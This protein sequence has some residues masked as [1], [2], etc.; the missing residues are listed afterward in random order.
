MYGGRG[1]TVN[2]LLTALAKILSRHL[3]ANKQI[4]F[5]FQQKSSI[6]PVMNS[7]PAEVVD[8][9]TFAEV[10]LIQYSAIAGHCLDLSLPIAPSLGKG[11]PIRLKQ[12]PPAWECHTHNILL[13]RPE[14]A[15]DP[16]KTRNNFRNSSFLKPDPQKDAACP[17]R[18]QNTLQRPGNNKRHGCRQQLKAPQVQLLKIFEHELGF[19][20][21]R[22]A[23]WRRQQWRGSNS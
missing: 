18:L 17:R 8:L 23:K 2:A 12:Y 13:K 21:L 9:F 7:N 16:Q 14:T 20:C 15:W 1:P 6:V 5:A 19:S 4:S 22:M 11:K 10:T 3:A